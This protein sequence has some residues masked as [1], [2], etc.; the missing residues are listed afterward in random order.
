MGIK[1][2]FMIPLDKK[3]KPNTIW[4]TFNYDP[5]LDSVVSEIV[6]YIEDCLCTCCIKGGN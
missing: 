2:E 5:S 6:D 4:I 3:E 1:K